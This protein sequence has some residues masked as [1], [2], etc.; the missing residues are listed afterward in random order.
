M[1][2]SVH[3]VTKNTEALI[4]ASKE[5][6]LEVNS[7]KAKYQ[8]L[9][10]DQNA[11]RSHSVKTGNSFFERVEQS[12]Y[13]GTSVVDRNCI[14]EEIKSKFKSGNACCHS[15]QNLLHSSLLS[16]NIIRYT[17]P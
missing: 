5:T 8:V 1:G 3:T 10:R 9:S 11:R 7:H 15:V 13:L 16:K 2:G 4:V 6:G 17:E 14:Q 12:K